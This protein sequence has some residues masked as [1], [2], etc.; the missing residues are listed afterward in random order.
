M[1]NL[2]LANITL[3]KYAY[4]EDEQTYENTVRIVWAENTTEAYDICHKE[5]DHHDQYGFS[6]V[7][8]SLEISEA[9]GSMI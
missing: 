9:L 3:R 8:D 6:S 5:L 2:Y 7:I 4:M 1:K